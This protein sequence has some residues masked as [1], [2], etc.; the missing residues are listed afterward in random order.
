MIFLIYQIG[1]YRYV[2]DMTINGKYVGFRV[3]NE[4]LI[5]DSNNNPN[6]KDKILI[7]LR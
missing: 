4:N 7:N 1:N 2:I 6:D 5:Y 3:G